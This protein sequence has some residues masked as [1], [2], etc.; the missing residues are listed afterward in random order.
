MIKSK[1]FKHSFDELSFGEASAPRD[2]STGFAVRLRM[3]PAKDQF[4]R[5]NYPDARAER[6]HFELPGTLKIVT[7][8][9][10]HGDR[11]NVPAR[12]WISKCCT[13]GKDGLAPIVEARIYLT[14]PDHPHGTNGKWHEL[15]VGFPLALFDDLPGRDVVLVYDGVNFYFTVDGELVDEEK[16]A[17]TLDKPF[18]DNY[19]LDRDFFPVFSVS[20]DVRSIKRSVIEKVSDKSVNYYKPEGFNTFV[21][22][23]VN[24]F[25]DG[26][27]HVLYL[28][29]RRQHGK[30]WGGGAHYFHHLTTTDLRDWTDHG[31]VFELKEP[32]QSVGTG[33]MFH[34]KGK[35]W[36]TFGWHSNRVVP[37]ERTA[38]PLLD[39]YYKEHGV[40]RAIPYGELGGRT[41]SGANFAHSDDGIHFTLGDKVI[42]VA[43]NPST[44]QN[45]DGTLSMYE[46]GRSWQA[47]TVD[48]DWR[49]VSE[50]FPK[51]GADAYMGNSGECPSFFR[52]NGYKYLLL[53]GSGFYSGEEEGEWVD[54]AALG[55][56]IYDG[57][58]V[59]MVSR[60]K[61][62]RMLYAGW[63][64]NGSWASVLLQ[65]ELLQSPG[66]RLGMKWIPELAPAKD[67]LFASAGAGDAIIRL[68]KDRSFY[69]EAE[70]DPAD[71]TGKLALR[72]RNSE[73][74]ANDVELQLDLARERAQFASYHG[75]DCEAP[76]PTIREIID[77]QEKV[78]EGTR[79]YLP[80]AG[81]DAPLHFRG[82]NFCL[83][84]VDVMKRPFT[85]RVVA[86][87]SPSLRATIVDAEINGQR[88]MVS[89]RLGL[90]A[91][92]LELA[93][94]GGAAAL[95]V[96]VY[97][98]EEET[99][100]RPL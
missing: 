22:D 56:D 8:L 71:S 30:R 93:A 17:G 10:V 70:L 88:T 3:A 1:L 33:T 37:A 46:W 55:F 34:H 24:F 42:H 21:G 59:P 74:P 11:Q 49:L 2:L 29:D 18:S 75:G 81:G 78:K 99:G 43:E 92:T 72:L 73:A 67:E 50:G 60:F 14:H 76:V 86:R 48:A 15:S 98:Y 16:P 90:H 66:G 39:A 44:Y 41:P 100:K 89:R 79:Q 69:I 5:K 7:R 45:P 94:A 26:V 36:I 62:N 6:V 96:K 58:F 54:S 82:F 4:T 28:I 32:W 68:E 23:V 80:F 84:R 51:C 52:W 12:D 65:R 35:Y 91:D 20:A 27:Y 87:Y 47:D 61:D 85:L 63:V 25:H 13:H 64:G 57:Q 9:G 53:G 31:P 83:E 95:G 38:S 40:M 77:S 97:R 19:V